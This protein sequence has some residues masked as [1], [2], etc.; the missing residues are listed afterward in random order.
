MDMVKYQAGLTILANSGWKK[1]D[2]GWFEKDGVTLFYDMLED[3]GKP[4]SYILMFMK[5]DKVQ[6]NLFDYLPEKIESPI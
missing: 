4:D 3:E 2:K 1:N 6:T 5:D